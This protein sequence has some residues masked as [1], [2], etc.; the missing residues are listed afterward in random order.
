MKPLHFSQLKKNLATA[1]A[2]TLL[3]SVN[4]TIYAAHPFQNSTDQNNHYNQYKG[5]VIDENSKESLAF[6]TLSIE[7]TNITT[8]TNVEG[9][10]LLKVPKD[11]NENNVVIS[12][13]GY[14]NK[15]IPL[16][17]LKAD[18]NNIA[19]EA[20]ITELSEINIET[21]KN[22][23]ELV[24]ETLKKKGENYFSDPTLM[25]AF[26]RETIK[27]RKQNISLS[28][29]VVNIYKMPYMSQKIDK[30]KFYKSRKSSNYKKLDTL[31]LKLQGGPFNTIF[32]DIMK[33]PEYIFAEESL[34][35]YVFSLDH[36]TKIKNRL[37][38]VINFEQGDNIK[39]PLYKGQ[40]FIDAE[41]KILT[42]AVYSLN[43]TDKKAVAQMFV[44]KKPSRAD[45]WPKEIAYRVDYLEKDNKWYYG[46]SKL[47]LEFKVNWD[48]K[49]FNSVYSMV[50][51]MAVTDWEKHINKDIPK[52]KERIKPSIIMHDTSIG[53]S[54]PNFWGEYNI[55]E[56]DKS[57]NFAIKK[58]RKQL[59][60]AK[61]KSTVLAK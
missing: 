17:E 5:R 4:Q 38:Y 30:L 49:L 36:S 14:K 20:H 54:D 56:P 7:G 15:V 45:V 51:E 10:F 43:I 44:R 39:T 35:N 18:K 26:Y 13:L 2:F 1:L 28:E 57:I 52:Y 31:V 19:L 33:Y 41:K 3:L 55:I 29:A 9:K 48:N 32:I 27:K 47:L 42:S 21:I 34:N 37:I 58:I 24:R 61:S 59:K 8:I 11:I 50:C 16:A 60:K 12:S 22:A 53:F 46:Y 23:R 25:T 6:S 40:L